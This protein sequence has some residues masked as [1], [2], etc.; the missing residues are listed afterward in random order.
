MSEASVRVIPTDDLVINENSPRAPLWWGMVWLIIIEAMVFLGLIVSYFYLR[1][2]APTWP[3]G[4]IEPPELTL[5]T[6]SALTLWISSAPMCRA[7]SS[8]RKGDVK[9]LKI[10]LA[11][12]FA[13]GLIFL[14]LKYIEYSGL[15]YN[16]ATNA[17]G[18]I[19]WAIT[20]FHSAHVLAVL[21]ET[22]V[23]FAAASRGYFSAHRNL[24]VR[25]NGLYWHFVVAI[26]VPLYVTLYL[27]HLV[28]QPR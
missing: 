10:G 12:S 20:G 4:D 14:I 1:Y 15:D 26:W 5:P 6:I 17:Y 11:I 16:W 22:V 28:L 7:D 23:V 8:I 25:I 24:G 2:Y 9:K 13:L 21:L 3:L 27:S 19:V 18:S